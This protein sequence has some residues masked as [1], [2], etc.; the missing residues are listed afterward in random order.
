MRAVTTSEHDLT[1][2]IDVPNLTRYLAERLP[3]SDAPLHIER[4]E[5]GYSNETFYITRGEDRW[6]M[7]RPPR[8]VFLPTAHD[9]LREYRVLTGLHGAG[10]RTPRTVLAC[11]D[12]GVLGAPFYLMERVEGTVIREEMPPALDTSAERR[13]IGEEL[14]DALAELHAV[15]YVASGLEGLGRPSGYLERQLRRWSGQLELTLQRTRPLPGIEVVHGWLADRL[16]ESGPPAIV[17]GDY[18]LDNV[19]MSAGAP[20]R[21]LAILD[22]EMATIGDPLADLG[23]LMAYWGPTGEAVE[24][25]LAGSNQLTT[26]LPGFLSQEEMIARYEARTGRPMLHFPFYLCLAVWK[27]TIIVEGLYAHYL[28]G[29]A[30]NTRAAEFE[31]RVPLLVERMHR[32]MADA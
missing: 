8:G 1:G 13:R 2:L 5:A 26:V 3:G 16:P 25:M 28:D 14:I 23:W 15:D 24:N 30:A 29:T 21:L 32:I 31:W 19:V 9:V 20:A 18:K 4:H 10:V 11:E 6:V 17:H 7:R 12:A 27:L 22:W